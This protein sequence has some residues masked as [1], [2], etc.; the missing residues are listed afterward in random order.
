MGMFDGGGGLGA[1]G[2]AILQAAL[3][4]RQPGGGVSA[5]G[6]PGAGAPMAPGGGMGMLSQLFDPK[7]PGGN[8]GLLAKLRGMMGPQQ[9]A[10]PMSL[11]PPGMGSGPMMPDAPPVNTLAPW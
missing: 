4:A 2:M 11:A 8:N 5:P 7:N 1:Q 3:K 10:A 9:P 6:M